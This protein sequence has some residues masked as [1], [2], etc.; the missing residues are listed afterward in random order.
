MR[1]GEPTMLRRVSSA[2]ERFHEAC[3]EI[4]EHGV[5]RKRVVED[6]AT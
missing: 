2:D 1:T 3:H 5:V 6:V 4:A